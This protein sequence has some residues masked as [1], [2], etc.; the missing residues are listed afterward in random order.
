MAAFWQSAWAVAK[1]HR[2]E[3]SSEELKT[4]GKTEHIKIQNTQKR[5]EGGLKYSEGSRRSISADSQQPVSLRPGADLW[6]VSVRWDSPSHWRVTPGFVCFSSVTNT[7]PNPRTK[8]GF[9]LLLFFLPPKWSGG[10][11]A[12]VPELCWR[13]LGVPCQEWLA[14]LADRFSE[15]QDNVGKF[16]FAGLFLQT[17]KKIFK[18]NEKLTSVHHFY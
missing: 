17:V 2:L 1:E 5:P 4:T 18:K 15:S 3:S 14:A 7:A 11:L 8:L 9:L 13:G 16:V 10:T 12:V 6:P